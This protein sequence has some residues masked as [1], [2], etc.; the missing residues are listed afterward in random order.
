LT[1]E[2][3]LIA[4]GND[5][6]FGQTNVPPGLSNVVAIAASGDYNLALT[7]PPRIPPQLTVGRD[8]A[9]RF[10]VGISTRRGTSYQLDFAETLS[11]RTWQP[12]ATPP[13]PGNG[14]I[15]LLPDPLPAGPARFFRVRTR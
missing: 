1:C 11:P 3:T 7:G 6:T 15:L 10:M 13:V 8:P 2:G 9:S 4:W 12:V 5:N 14:S